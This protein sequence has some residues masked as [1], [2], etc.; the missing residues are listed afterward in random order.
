MSPAF[1]SNPPYECLVPW[2]Q[3]LVYLYIND[4]LALGS[5]ARWTFLIVALFTNCS[6]MT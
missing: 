1:G 3:S 2:L 6:N 5:E 4:S